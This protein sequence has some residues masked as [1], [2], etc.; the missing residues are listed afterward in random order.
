MG[1]YRVTA[2]IPVFVSVKNIDAADEEDAIEKAYEHLSLTSY[3]GNGGTNKLV[4]V[5]G[6]DV[7]VEAGEYLIECDGYEIEVEEM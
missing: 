6:E 2:S 5:S 4:G 3:A 1:K 7:S